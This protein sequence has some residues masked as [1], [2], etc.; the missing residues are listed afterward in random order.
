MKTISKIAL[1]SASAAAAVSLAGGT[2]IME[3]SVH[4]SRQTLEQAQAWQQEH[5]DTSFYEELEK[6]KYIIRGYEDYELHACFVK[7]P[8]ETDRYVILTHGYTDNRMGSLKY[9][10]LYLDLGFHCIIYDLRDHGE[11]KRSFCSY[12]LLEAKDLIAV[13]DD[14]YTRYGENIHIGL[15]G[16]SLGAATTVRSLMYHPKVEFAVADCGFADITNVLEGIMAYRHIPKFLVGIASGLTKR[17]YGYSFSEMRPIDALA[18]NKVPIL[19]IHGEEDHFILPENS[20]RM[21]DATGGYAELW[22]VP[23]AHHAGS[24]LTDPAGYAAHVKDFLDNIQMT[25]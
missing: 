18:E 9:M 19:F 3:S 21:K 20:I 24:V 6:T 1:A 25:L 2:F 16:E 13:I 10:K 14:T 5:Y 15:H 8:G 23:G 22:L 4:G 17:K 12:S 11:N 7:N